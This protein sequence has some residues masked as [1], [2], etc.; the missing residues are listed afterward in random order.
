V[1]L[2]P[3]LSR[4]Q[5]SFSSTAADLGDGEHDVPQQRGVEADLGSVKP[6]AVLA[7]L[8]PPGGAG[9]GE[10]RVRPGGAALEL[11]RHP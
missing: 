8:E 11:L 2:V 10:G 4:N 5:A 6:E 7:E 3:D 1:S 9:E